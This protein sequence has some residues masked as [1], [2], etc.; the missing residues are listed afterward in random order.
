MCGQKPPLQLKLH[1]SQIDPLD[2]H[3][4]Q[5]GAAFTKWLNLS[6]MWKMLI[7][8]PRA[9]TL[10][11]LDSLWQTLLL[12]GLRLYLTRVSMKMLFSSFKQILNFTTDIAFGCICIWHMSQCGSF[13]FHIFEF[14]F[15][16]LRQ[17]L[18]LASESDTCLN[19]NAFF[20]I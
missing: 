7:K 13:K 18:L 15:K 17:T 19:V 4:I 5:C 6:K 10:K 20:I 3:L 14:K 11:Y 9:P 12:G 8:F 1:L 16:I 2:R